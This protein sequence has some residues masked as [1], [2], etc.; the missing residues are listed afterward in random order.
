MKCRLEDLYLLWTVEKKYKVSKRLRWRWTTG[1]YDER[2]LVGAVPVTTGRFSAW[3]SWEKT[4]IELDQLLRR[5]WENSGPKCQSSESIMYLDRWHVCTY[6]WCVCVLKWIFFYLIKSSYF[7]MFH[8][9][10]FVCVLSLIDN[11]NIV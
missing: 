10:L 8:I 6:V 9:S 1:G 11:D 2:T 3:L 4:R 7:I 5:L